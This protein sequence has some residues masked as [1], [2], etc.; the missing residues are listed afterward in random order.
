MD[1]FAFIQK[2]DYMLSEHGVCQD[3]SIPTSASETKARRRTGP[4]DVTAKAAPLRSPF[5]TRLADV[6]NPLHCFPQHPIS[7]YQE[8]SA[9]V[10]RLPVAANTAQLVGA[11]VYEPTASTD[12]WIRPCAIWRFPVL[13]RVDTFCLTRRL[14]ACRYGDSSDVP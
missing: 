1:F 9:D 11:F 3:W 8:L 4:T 12:S 10:A 7:T 2:G 14:L 13:S 5:S 6:V